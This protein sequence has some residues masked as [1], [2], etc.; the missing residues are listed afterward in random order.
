MQSSKWMATLVCAVTAIVA[1]PTARSDGVCNAGSRTFTVAERA[2]MTVVLETVRM[3]LPPTPPGWVIVG[4]DQV[5]VPTG[6]CRDYERVPW[7]Y[8]FTRYYQDVGNQEARAKIMDEAGA[9]SAAALK[10]KQPRIDAL[11]ARMD[12]LAKTYAD[13]VVKGDTERAAA[14]YTEVTKGQE[15][16]EKILKEGDSEQQIAAAADKAGRDIKMQI[17][18]KINADSETP[19]VSAKILPLPTGA[20]VAVHWFQNGRDP[21]EDSALILI[22]QWAAGSQGSWQSLRRA[23]APAYAAH[24]MSIHVAADSNRLASAVSSIDVKRM[25]ALLLN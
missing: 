14:T 7:K 15:E 6:M 25:A 5:S 21:H 16:Y 13:F 22:G 23:N 8:E 11:M 17:T 24:A 9:A 18:V 10:L 4:D 2:A 19:D 1:A 3:S 20:R 12:K